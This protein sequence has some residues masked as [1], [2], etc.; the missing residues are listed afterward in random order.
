MQVR[1][2]AV[3]VALGIAFAGIAAADEI[4]YFTNGTAMAIRSH[5]LEN[6]MIR[7][8]LGNNS[9]MAFP[10]SMVE[11]VESAGRNVFQNPTFGPANQ[12][13]GPVGTSGGGTHYPAEAQGA[14][15]GYATTPSRNR[16]S[17]SA[18][19]RERMDPEE[20]L[21]M[22]A[23]GNPAPA[24]TSA[25]PTAAARRMRVIGRTNGVPGEDG[26]FQRGGLTVIGSPG[27]PT[28]PAGATTRKPIVSFGPKT[29]ETI[30]A[31]EPT[32]DADEPAEGNDDPGDPDNAQPSPE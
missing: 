21:A 6:D 27:I 4:V 15:T 17:A 16:Q 32:P 20:Q 24:E 13:V 7:V 22:A 28:D 2:L 11:K 31:P 8:D 26:T 14:V 30:E 23:Q 1:G 3:V 5:K 19:R 18:R 12:A 25:G 29:T 9:A 10:V